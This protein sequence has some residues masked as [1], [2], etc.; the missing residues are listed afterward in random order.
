[1]EKGGFSTNG[2]K[3]IKCPYSK[4]MNL[5]LY[6]N[7]NMKISSRWPIDL[8]A[9]PLGDDEGKCLCNLGVNGTAKIIIT[10]GKRVS[11]I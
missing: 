3:T 7:P 11:Y 10:K 5:N 9:K 4:K 6:S 2:A 8:T 1:M